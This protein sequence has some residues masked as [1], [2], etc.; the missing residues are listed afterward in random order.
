M[1]LTFSFTLTLCF[2]ILCNFLKA[3]LKEYINFSVIDPDVILKNHIKDRRKEIYSSLIELE[4][5]A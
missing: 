5:H 2:V 3:S 4:F 1:N